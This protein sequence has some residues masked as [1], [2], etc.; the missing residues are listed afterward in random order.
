ME[1]EMAKEIL[2]E[3]AEYFVTFGQNKL[4]SNLDED[5]QELMEE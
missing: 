4:F 5:M 2:S 3:E 1:G